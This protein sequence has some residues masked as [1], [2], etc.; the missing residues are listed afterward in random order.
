MSWREEAKHDGG[1]RQVA[2]QQVDVLV[3]AVETDD[4]GEEV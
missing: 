4:V 1:G 2:I 3:V